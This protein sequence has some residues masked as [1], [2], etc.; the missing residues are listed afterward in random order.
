MNF[1]A[2]I[3]RENEHGDF[4]N[5]IV[6]KSIED[7]PKGNLLVRVEYSSLNYKDALSASGNKGVT[8]KYPHTPGIDA[9]GVIEESSDS[10]FTKNSSV[11]VSG[12]DLGMNTDGGS[13]NIFEYHL[14]GL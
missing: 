9:A 3:T 10:N 12:Y 7:L 1:R 14:H 8:K 2:L 13:D 6:R 11:I 4:E 5:T